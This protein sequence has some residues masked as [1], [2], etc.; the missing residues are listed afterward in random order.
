MDEEIK[1]WLQWLGKMK[2]GI[3]RNDWKENYIEILFQ[4]W[5]DWKGWGING[6]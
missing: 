6:R 3:H 1:K 5:A 4:K 2:V